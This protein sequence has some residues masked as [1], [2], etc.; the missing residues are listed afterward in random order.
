MSLATGC[1][2]RWFWSA[3]MG[4][5]KSGGNFYM[6]FGTLGHTALAYHYAQQMARKPQWLIDQPDAEIALEMDSLGEAGWL[7]TVKELLKAY[8]AHYAVDTWKPLYVEEEFLSTVGQL[9][10]EGVDEPPIGP[11]EFTDIHGRQRVL[12]RPSLNE[13]VVSCRPDIIAEEHG[14]L[15]VGDHK[16]QGGGQRSNKDRLPIVSDDYP[17]Y[18]YMWQAMVNLTIVRQHLPVEAFVFN[19]LKRNVP[20]D[21]SRDPV[22]VYQRNM[23][24][25]PKAIRAAVKRRREVMLKAA[26][27]PNELVPRFSECTYCDYTRLCYTDTREER[28]ARLLSEYVVDATRF[29]VRTATLHVSEPSEGGV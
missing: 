10:P 27:M 17:D 28:D 6:D 14:R 13:E 16:V 5:Q 20:F 3:F 15:I 23:R 11:I 9:D 22:T 7:R 21:F 29:D 24:K 26:T 8:K 4:Y 19:R 12:Q 18:R 25:I 2:V 1:E